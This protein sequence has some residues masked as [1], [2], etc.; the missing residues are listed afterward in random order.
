VVVSLLRPTI[1]LPPKFEEMGLDD[2]QRLSPDDEALLRLCLL[3]ELAHAR[4]NDPAFQLIGSLAQ[5]FWFFLPQ[6]WWIRA[7]L[8]LDQ[9]FVADHVASVAY[10]TSYQYAASLLDLAASG[11]PSPAIERQDAPPVENPTG[12][13]G[14]AVSSAGE[15]AS[16]L[17]QRLLMLLHCPYRLEPKAPT[18]WLWGLRFA[19]L[20]GTLMLANVSV[21]PPGF[22]FAPSHHSAPSIDG[23]FLSGMNRF[24]VSELIIDPN[25]HAETAR[26]DSYVVP[27]R[28][29]EH[30]SM[31]LDVLA[32]EERL[33]HIRLM[34]LPLGPTEVW[35]DHSSSLNPRLA[36]HLGGPGKAE[37]ELW[38][39]IRIERNDRGMSLSVDQHALP[40]PAKPTNELL[41]VEPS[42]GQPVEL[43][44]LIVTPTS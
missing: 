31:T 17:G 7:Q 32:T 19:G 16:C 33:S 14:S 35:S 41:R 21:T 12:N 3:H 29:P 9:E 22:G 18:G 25:Q 10:G 24:R 5:A 13:R 42:V 39:R 43:R 20:A 2:Q 27:F 1:L 40:C 15:S 23:I 38:H 30:Y 34:N 44:N 4:R 26:S 11:T 36:S 6:L 8:R 28:L 37:R